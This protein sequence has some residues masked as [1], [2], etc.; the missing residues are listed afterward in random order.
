M[1]MVPARKPL[2]G[3][4]LAAFHRILCPSL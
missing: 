4:E 1:E 2:A 3:I